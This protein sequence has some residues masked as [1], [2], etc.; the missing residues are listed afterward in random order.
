MTMAIFTAD[1]AKFFPIHILGPQPNGKNGTWLFVAVD[2]PPEN[3]SGLNSYA[4]SP[5]SLR[6]WCTNIVGIA[7]CTPGGRTTFLICISL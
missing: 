6:L 5:Q 1:K 2:N 3:L 4:T 7:I